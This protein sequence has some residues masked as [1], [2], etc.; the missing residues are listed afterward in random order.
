M[1]RFVTL[2]S[3]LL[4]GTACSPKGEQATEWPWTDPDP[5]DKEE[6][7]VTD[8]NPAI[9]EKGW[10]AVSF[11]G[12]PEGI[13][14]YKS[15]SSL[16]GVQAI[17]YIAV[18]EPDKIVWDVW[19]IDDPETTGTAD[20]LKTPSQ[21]W[22]EGK[23]PVIVNG[24]Y[25]FSEGGKNYNASVAVS[26]G[27]VYGVNLNYASEDWE[28]Y[29]YPTRGVFYEKAGKMACGWTYYTPSGQHYL[30]DTPALNSW[31]FVRW[32]SLIS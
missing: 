12:V 29:Y 16:Q 9:V 26:N 23:D 1:I 4:L 28:T 2:L 10:T 13:R 19:S 25:F 31:R 32:I 8:P 17:A 7:V 30:Y 24:G 14:I 20:A 27:R 22:K 3:A 11:D 18:A 5:K 6:T 21:R 15:P